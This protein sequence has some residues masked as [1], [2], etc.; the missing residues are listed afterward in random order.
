LATGG[1]LETNGINPIAPQPVTS[2]PV[3]RQASQ[4]PEEAQT[5]PPDQSTGNRNRHQL[6]ELVSCHPAP[7]PSALV[8]GAVKLYRIPEF[9]GGMSHRTYRAVAFGEKQQMV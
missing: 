3:S 8:V 7:N 1:W 5:K 9:P 6:K 2:S 4:Q